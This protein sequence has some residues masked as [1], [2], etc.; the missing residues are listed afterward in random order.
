M[1]K[2]QIRYAT[3]ATENFFEV[4]DPQNAHKTKIIVDFFKAY[5][6][7]LLRKAPIINYVD[8]F[9]G[10]GFY[11]K[12]ALE[13]SR[14][15]PIPATPLEILTAIDT[16]Q[17]APRTVTWFNEGDPRHFEDLRAA[18]LAHPTYPKLV[19]KP[20][21]TNNDV[22]ERMTNFFATRVN[23][24]TFMFVDPYGY[25][26]LT[27]DLIAAVLKDWGCDVAFFFNYRR[28]NM[29]VGH[30]LFDE[31]LSAIFGEARLEQLRSELQSIDDPDDREDL[32]LR[33]LRAALFEIGGRHFLK[34]RFRL[35]DGRT[36]HHLVFTS[37]IRR[38]FS[39][40]KEKMSQHSW[41]DPVDEIPYFEFVP[42]PKTALTLFEPQV[43]LPPRNWNFS[44]KALSN[45]LSQR[46]RGRTVTLESLY[47]AYNDELPY[48][49]KHYR[50]A[51]WI[52]QD[53][54]LATMTRAD[55]KPP[56]RNQCP[57]DTS[58]RL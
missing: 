56:R 13:P 55:G 6:V 16:P 34:Y 27:R 20:S 32:I 40:M 44:V 12:C 41:K 46:F 1:A 18:I 53:R 10:R 37:K 26:G 2:K 31:H 58:I 24:P 19:H 33:N 39:T 54:G 50:A 29:A 48:E 3:D 38:G 11:D 23:E 22:N 52:L 57:E 8:P 30:G 9:A 7:I 35:W 28:V 17:F 42:Q 45:E 25:R 5:A 43:I 21:I 47:A 14:V 49:L 15:G 51:L 4:R 36:S